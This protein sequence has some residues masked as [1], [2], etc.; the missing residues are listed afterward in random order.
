MTTK[1]DHIARRQAKAQYDIEN[2]DWLLPLRESFHTWLVLQ[3]WAKQE[4]PAPGRSY[5]GSH[6]QDLWECWLAATL[7]EQSIKQEA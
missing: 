2:A 4:T 6:T 5:P 3:G 7:I 1:Q